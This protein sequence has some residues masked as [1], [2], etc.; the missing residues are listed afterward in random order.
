VTRITQ[1]MISRTLLADLNATT[2]RMAATQHKMSSG[3][4]LTKPSDDPFGVSR[5]LQFRGDLAANRQHQRNV[6]EADAWQT[7]TDT[8]LGQIGDIALRPRELVVQ[9]ANGATGPQAR[10]AIATEIEQLVD[11]LKSVANAQYAGRYVFAGS[12]TLT[13]PYQLGANDTYGGN[14]ET[15]RREIGPNVQIDLN[16]TGGAVIGDGSGGLIATLRKVAADLRANDTAALQNGDLSAI[17]A[18]HDTIVSARATVGARANRLET[19][20]GRLQEVED[21]TARLLSE[22]EDADM[23]KTL[24]DF[25]MQQAVYQSAL[26]AGANVI[27]PSL[28]DFLR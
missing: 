21:T 15:L 13:P 28:M 17:D 24:I 12:D 11:S 7:V 4:E 16:V 3:K 18:A 5:A 10:D 26:K 1:N 23:A 27:Q 9:G 20:A 14:A 6:S 22:T 8:A 2:A 25:S 19:A